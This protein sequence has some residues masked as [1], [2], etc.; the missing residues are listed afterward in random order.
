MP[1]HWNLVCKISMMVFALQ[2]VDI[3]FML[4]KIIMNFSG[5]YDAKC[6][7]LKNIFFFFKEKTEA[8]WI[9]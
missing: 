4:Q 3:V 2:N 6:V 5:F 1:Y 9:F 7:L 8:R